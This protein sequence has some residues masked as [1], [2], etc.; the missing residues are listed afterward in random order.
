MYRIT[1]GM[2][3]PCNNPISAR[4]A[5]NE[6]LANELR[7]QFCEEEGELGDRVTE[8]V[9]CASI[10]MMTDCEYERETLPFVERP[11]SSKKLSVFA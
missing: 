10:K 4:H 8:I 3:P 5:R 7:G 9:V 1:S 11:R 2:N 6:F